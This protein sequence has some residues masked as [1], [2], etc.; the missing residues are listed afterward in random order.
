VNRKPKVVKQSDGTYSIDWGN[1]VLDGE[2]DCDDFLEYRYQVNKHENP[3]CECGAHVTYGK[4]CSSACHYHY[5]DF[6]EENSK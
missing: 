1:V 2:S 3:V 6:S 5:C 4:D